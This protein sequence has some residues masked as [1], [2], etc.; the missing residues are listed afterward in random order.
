MPESPM[1]EQRVMQ[2]PAEHCQGLLAATRGWE[3]A[4][5]EAALEPLE[6]AWLSQHLDFNPLALELK[7]I[8]FYCLKK[9]SL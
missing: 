6:G 5:K 2:L 8:D 3:E 1:T 4:R 9:L 7:R